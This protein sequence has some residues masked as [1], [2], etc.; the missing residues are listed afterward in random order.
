MSKN[1]TTYSQNGSKTTVSIK[2][3]PFSVQLVWKEA[4]KNG[5]AI[6][7]VRSNQTRYDT[8]NGKTFHGIHHGLVSV[9]TP[10]HN[11]TKK[12]WFK[13]LLGRTETNPSM[14]I[15]EVPNTSYDIE[16]ILRV[17]N[18]AVG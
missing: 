15:L 4:D 7:R 3:A 1:S 17:V 10:R 14:Q 8:T 13:K 6:I 12:L 18:Y 16:D 2:E 9:Y 5:A 11:P